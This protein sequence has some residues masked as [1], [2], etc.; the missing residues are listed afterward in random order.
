MEGLHNSLDGGGREEGRRKGRGK[1]GEKKL[2][3]G[4][5]ECALPSYR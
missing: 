2:V 5:S 4:A 1:G 3:I